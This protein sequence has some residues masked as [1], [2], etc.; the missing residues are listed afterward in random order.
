VSETIAALATAPGRSAVAVVRIS[1]PGARSALAVLGVRPGRPRRA[2]LRQLRDVDGGLIDTALVLWFEAPASYTGEDCAELHLHGGRFVVERVLD[3]LLAKGVRLAEPGEFTRRAFEHG[4]LDL[5][6]AE[7]VADLVDAESEAQARQA[8]DQLG[9]ALSR[10][11]ERWRMLLIEALARLEAA[12]DFP[13]EDIEPALGVAA[14]CLEGVLE[15]L[16]AALAGAGRGQAVREGYRI[17]I[18]GAPNA[19]KSTLLNALVG[20]DMAIVTPT[21]GTTRDVIEVSGDIAG[22][23]VVIADMAGL[24]EASDDIEAEGVRRAQAW[25]SAADLRIWVVDAAD[26][27]P[28]WRDARRL[29]LPGDIVALNKVDLLATGAGGAQ[30]VMTDQAAII[31]HNSVRISAATGELAELRDWL[32][33]KVIADLGSA[34]F[35]A[36]TRARH[37]EALRSAA[38]HVSAALAEM[39]APELAAENA[40]LAVRALARVTGEV[41]AEDVLDLVFSTFCIGK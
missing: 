30:D 9:G 38:D 32:E 27:G 15:E 4:K 5:A 19:G 3:R 35:P 18:I 7:A 13:D 33:K 10:T 11:H 17:A 12:V 40:R 23:R 24:R 22:Y 28:H 34:E 26:A 1:G 41:G 20:R 25:A 8:L 16:K 37:V 29:V 14:A 36:A 39:A 2:V 21:A 31:G 6:Q